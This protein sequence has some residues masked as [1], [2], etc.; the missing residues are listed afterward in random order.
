M[1]KEG[2]QTNKIDMTVYIEHNRPLLLK[3]INKQFEMLGLDLKYENIP[4]D[5]KLQT[6]TR[7][8]YWYEIYNFTTEEQYRTWVDY[9]EKEVRGAAYVEPEAEVM[10][11]DLRYGLNY[12]NKPLTQ[13][14]QLS[15]L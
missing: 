8:V 10:Y 13:G 1:D 6:K 12:I 9:V 5:G 14:T 15:M 3:L 7:R 4:D 11:I 2:R